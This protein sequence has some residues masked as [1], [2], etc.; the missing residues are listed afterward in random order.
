MKYILSLLLVGFTF[1]IQAQQTTQ[2]DLETLCRICREKQY[3]NKAS[4]CSNT[5]CRN[6]QAELASSSR[7]PSLTGTSGMGMRLGRSIDPTT[8]GFTNTQFLYNNFGLNGGVQLY[9]CW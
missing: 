1:Q 2:W 9:K 8:N 6:L 3:F 4:R 7:L 5:T